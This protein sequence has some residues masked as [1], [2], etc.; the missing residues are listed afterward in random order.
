M[1]FRTRA[2]DAIAEAEA[3]LKKARLALLQRASPHQEALVNLSNA[4]QHA[5]EAIGEI[6]EQTT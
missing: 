5:A 6:G 3:S 4:I 1:G 2:L